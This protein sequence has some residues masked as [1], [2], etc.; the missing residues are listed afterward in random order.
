MLYQD[1]HFLIPLTLILKLVMDIAFKIMSHPCH[2]LYLMM[3]IAFK[4]INLFC[5]FMY[6][7]FKGSA[8]I[9]IQY[10]LVQL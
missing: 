10:Y 9:F 5:Y 1:K 3:D 8:H 4:N 2:I 7:Q 6:G